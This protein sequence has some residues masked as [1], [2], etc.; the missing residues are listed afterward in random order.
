[1]PET[2]IP[3][4]LLSSQ[5]FKRDVIGLLGLSPKVIGE[6]GALVRTEDAEALSDAA[7]AKVADQHDLPRDLVF[8][9]AAVLSYV[10]GRLRERGLDS[11]QGVQELEVLQPGTTS[12]EVSASLLAAL[13]YTKE[14]QAAAM[15]RR[16]FSIGAT[17]LST[18]MRP[19]LL[20]VPD[21]L[22]V[23]YPGLFWT[24]TYLDSE[25]ELK[26]FTFGLSREELQGLRRKL[27][28][29]L[30]ELTKVAERIRE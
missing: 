28:V 23:L 10:R 15:A 1:M 14:E 8:R 17:Y 3:A 2:V 16:A 19:A 5:D 6:L 13:E 24:I 7:T 30:D 12:P 29:A 4:T 22:S 20:P 9:A 25:S 27:D 21:D 11:K 18:A 26:S